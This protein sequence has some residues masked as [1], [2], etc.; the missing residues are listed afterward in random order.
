MSQQPAD[1]ATSQNVQS[2]RLLQIPAEILDRITWHLT[3]PELC[4][5]RITCKSVEEALYYSFTTEF[6]T[7]KQFMISEFSLR[8]LVDISK[9]RLAGHL[10][11]VHF[12]LD[13]LGI[14]TTPSMGGEKA[15]MFAQRL[16][17]Q[18]TLWS[19]G[20]VPKYLTEAFSNLPNL[21]TVVVRDF[22]SN[23]RSRDGPHAHWLSYGTQTLL[24]ETSVRP[25]NHGI[26]G[27][28]SMEY[29]FVDQ[30]FKGIIHALGTANARPK[31]IEVMERQGHP[32]FDSAFHM[33]PDFE[34][35]I[36][37]VLRGLKR[38]HLTLE[39]NSS[40]IGDDDLP[41]QRHSLTKFLRHCDGLEELRING[42]HSASL[43]DTRNSLRNLYDWLT[44]TDS[45]SETETQKE[46]KSPSPNG[47]TSDISLLN[48]PIKFPR[49]QNISLGMTSFTVD[50]LV[51]LIARFA[52][53]VQNLELWRIKLVSDDRTLDQSQVL[54]DRQIL[55]AQVLKKLLN[56][57]NLN[58][59]HIKL[60]NMQQIWYPVNGHHILEEINFKP[61]AKTKDE[62]VDAGV[63]RVTGGTLQYTG[64]DWR[65]FVAYEMI[66][67]LY[68]PRV[69]YEEASQDEDN[70]DE[71]DEDND[72]D[73][74][75]DDDENMD[76]DE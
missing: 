13:Q 16:V 21:E 55:F 48:A 67:R 20:L 27:R 37:P 8:A 73:D 19:L 57:P 35:S 50:E 44:A 11:H 3:T 64:T 4:N 41:Y 36:I 6:F 52:D 15:R 49:L 17:E 9:S 51:R 5:L 29:G 47:Q 33:H 42:R 72:D 66:P 31:A 53:T 23:R 71:E 38:L 43:Y 1:M 59:R 68:T 30:M 46:A 39:A 58:L 2:C 14:H 32:L 28:G 56:I 18:E 25:T 62:D 76:Q 45:T 63:E 74:D 65:H 34:A 69:K 10:R 7:R 40:A 60:G 61:T 22:N 26:F 12:G 75:N 24:K 70:E 54:E